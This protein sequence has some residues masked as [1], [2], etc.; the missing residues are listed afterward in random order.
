L[1]ITFLRPIPSESASHADSDGIGVQNRDFFRFRQYTRVNPGG[2]VRRIPA[3][4]PRG[5]DVGRSDRSRG[6]QR[7]RPTSRSHRTE[8]PW[9]RSTC[10][11]R[12]LVMHLHMALPS[13]MSSS[14]GHVYLPRREDCELSYTRDRAP[15]RQS[16]ARLSSHVLDSR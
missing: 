2:V 5:R 12:W 6:R 10:R 7:R 16:V 4:G 14:S 9:I 8:A 1:K 3:V 13:L 11:G 15:A